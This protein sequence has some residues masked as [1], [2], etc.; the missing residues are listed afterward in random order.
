MNKMDTSHFQEMARRDRDKLIAG[1]VVMAVASVALI[2]AAA[3]AG[4]VAIVLGVL[5][6]VAP[7]RSRPSAISAC[8]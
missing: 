8:A 4:S 6:P 3:L 5:A 2:L 7:R 1:I